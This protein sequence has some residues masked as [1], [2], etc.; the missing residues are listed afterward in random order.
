VGGVVA[1]DGGVV[2]DEI[3]VP[4]AMTG[5][6]MAVGG[7]ATAPNT[8]DRRG[9]LARGDLARGDLVLPATPLGRCDGDE[10][11]AAFFLAPG[12]PLDALLL[13]F[14]LAPTVLLMFPRCWCW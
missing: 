13:G 14:P 9:D 4:A 1:A 3:G 2:V 12:L 11:S 10:I 5:A 6:E 7:P 8:A